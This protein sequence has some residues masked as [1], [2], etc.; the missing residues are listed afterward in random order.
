MT[1]IYLICGAILL[2][3]ACLAVI[4]AERGPSMLD[5]TIALDLFATVLVAGIAIEA[6]WSQR[7]DTLP[8]LVALS[9]V[10]FVSSVVIS[11]FASVEPDT[12]RRIKTAAEV[13]EE[14][15]RQR[16]AEEAADEEERLLH[17]QMLQEQ[18]AAEQLA[19]E[20]SAVQQAVAQQ[21]AAQQLAAQQLA[22]QQSGAEPEQKR[23]NQGEVN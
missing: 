5:R 1:V 8:I 7:V 9:M 3:S 20:Q 18:L 6:A 12:E 14:E 11:R 4:R 22:A 17:E 19:A 10:G 16:A 23:T 21:L 2:V 13:A 15:E